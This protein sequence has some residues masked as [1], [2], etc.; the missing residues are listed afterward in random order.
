[1]ARLANFFVFARY[2]TVILSEKSGVRD[3]FIYYVG[4][5]GLNRSH[6]LDVTGLTAIKRIYSILS[7]L[8]QTLMTIKTIAHSLRFN[9]VQSFRGPYVTVTAFTRLITGESLFL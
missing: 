6:L 9:F 4:K 7:D 8:A 5:T 2:F 3:R 1:M